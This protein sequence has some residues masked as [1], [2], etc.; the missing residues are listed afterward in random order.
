MR[1]FCCYRFLSDSFILPVTS[2]PVF[3]PGH[4]SSGSRTPTSSEGPAT[5]KNASGNDVSGTGLTGA[6]RN[7][8]M[9]KRYFFYY[10]YPVFT[11]S[12]C[13]KPDRRYQ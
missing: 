8:E 1:A 4:S 6:S 11:D 10:R 5:E 9:Y 7:N 3:E 2:A 12:A 13:G